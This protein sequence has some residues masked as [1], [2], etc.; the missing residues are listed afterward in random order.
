LPPATISGPATVGAET[1]LLREAAAALRAGDAAR[2]QALLDEHASSYPGGVMAE[3]RQAEMVSVL[4]ARGQTAR[5][6]DA[7]AAFLRDHPSSPLAARVRASCG[8]P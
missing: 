1:K 7:A 5:A 4:C 2:A 6:Q 8:R 3:E